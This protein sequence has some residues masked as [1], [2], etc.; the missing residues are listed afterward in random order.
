MVCAGVAVAPH[1]CVRAATQAAS[2]ESRK[3]MW[4]AMPCIEGIAN[5]R[6]AFIQFECGLTRLYLAPQRIVDNPKLR[7]VCQQPFVGRIE[8]GAASSALRILHE[9]LSIP[10]Q[11]TNIHLV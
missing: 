5:L 6:A 9:P 1:A 8:F 4:C 2:E 3:K 7:H 11:T 10:H